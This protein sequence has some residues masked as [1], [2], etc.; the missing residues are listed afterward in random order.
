MSY[1]STSIE[2]STASCPICQF[3]DIGWNGSVLDDED[4]DVDDVDEVDFDEDLDVDEVFDEDL[5]VDVLFDED[6]DVD[7][8]LGCFKEIDAILAFCDIVSDGLPKGLRPT[9]D[10]SQVQFD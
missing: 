7:D 2:K 8:T 3:H 5:N 6:L 1:I 4:L 10:A 9:A